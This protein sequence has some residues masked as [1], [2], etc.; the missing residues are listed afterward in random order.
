M[1]T[2]KYWLFDWIDAHGLRKSRQVETLLRDGRARADLARR[3]T[4][5]Y[6]DREGIIET[7]GATVIAGRPL[8]LSGQLDCI[9]WECI[10]KQLD[11][12]FTHVLHYFDHIV[13]A[14]INVGLAQA[15][16]SSQPD[17]S[18]IER[19]LGHIRILLYIREIGAEELLIFKPKPHFCESHM[20][21]S[22]KESG[23]R[24][25]I[26]ERIQDLSREAKVSV[27]ALNK[28]V[29]YAFTHPAFEHS[30]HGL[31]PAEDVAATDGD[32]E[33]VIV[34]GVLMDYLSAISSD[35]A[36]AKMWNSPLAGC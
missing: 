13:V 31:I 17:P 23:M 29:H 19:L 10:K 12:L 16:D 36:A 33:Q 24:D 14:G 3:A 4:D 34:R 15:C 26:A 21:E 9:Q 32:L 20:S 28:Y 30:I 22:L 35:L 7:R 5:S 25:T 1:A 2:A 11:N 27:E 18:T 6:S 8:D